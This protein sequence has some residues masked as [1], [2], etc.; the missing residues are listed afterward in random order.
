MLLSYPQLTFLYSAIYGFFGDELF[1]LFTDQKD[2]INASAPFQLWMAIIPVLAFAS[3]I[4]DGVYIGATATVPMRNSMLFCTF[5][6]FLP[7]YFL[8]KE[9]L[10][11]HSLWFALTSFM[12]ARG[13]SLHWYARKHVFV[14]RERPPAA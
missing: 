7:T 13:L 1:Y 2:V 6:I 12:V 8:L 10:G 5:L 9:A 3:Y 14:V 4:W 11:N